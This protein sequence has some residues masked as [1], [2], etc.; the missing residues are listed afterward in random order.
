MRSRLKL[1]DVMPA[2]KCDTTGAA[3]EYVVVTVEGSVTKL[4]VGSVI[5][6]N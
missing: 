5:Q 4:A 2:A 3:M 1:S 6:L